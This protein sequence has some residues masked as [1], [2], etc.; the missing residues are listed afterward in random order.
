M[1]GSNNGN[2]MLRR[3]LF[4]MAVAV[5]VLICYV[6]IAVRDFNDAEVRHRV[7]TTFGEIVKF[8]L[9]SSPE[10]E[11]QFDLPLS[12]AEVL[13][14]PDGNDVAEY[15]H[16]IPAGTYRYIT[17]KD[18]GNTAFVIVDPNIKPITSGYISK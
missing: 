4:W 13:Q 14:I 10:R 1:G 6:G 18:K 3:V 7:K 8:K 9:K 17:F 15:L 2:R 12:H 11:G 5:L 16:A